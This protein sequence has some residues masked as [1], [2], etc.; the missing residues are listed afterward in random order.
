M[1]KGAAR[2]VMAA[3]TL[4][5]LAGGYEEAFI[6]LDAVMIAAATEEEDGK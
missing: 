3:R 2:K 6:I 4:L 5:D 1:E